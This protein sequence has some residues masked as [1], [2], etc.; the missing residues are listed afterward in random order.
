MI[1]T[2]N[3]KRIKT[4]TTAA[5]AATTIIIMTTRQQQH[6]RWM[7][8]NGAVDYHNKVKGLQQQQQDE[9]LNLYNNIN[10]DLP[11]GLLLLLL[12]LFE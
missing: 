4:A 7:G 11:T 3:K 2:I 1:A 9:V 12:L 8:V 5:S 6:N 10:K